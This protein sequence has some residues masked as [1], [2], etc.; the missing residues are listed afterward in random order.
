MKRPVVLAVD[1]A[2]AVYA[3]LLNALAKTGERA[4][5]LD[6]Q[7]AAAEGSSGLEEAAALGVLRAVSVG[8]GRVRT[9][10]PIRGP[11]VLDDLLREHFR[12]CRLVLVRGGADLVRLEPQGDG[13][14]LTS[15][16]GGAVRRTTG[17]L[18]AGLGRP[19]LWRQDGAAAEPQEAGAD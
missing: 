14:L 19:S 7:P 15:P 5:W 16:A 3:P 6:L 18:V 2:A 9:L 13:W 12:G 1:A 10:K 8:G 11:A 4:G 17:E